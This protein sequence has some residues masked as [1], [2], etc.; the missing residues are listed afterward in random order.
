MPKFI[1]RWKRKGNWH[2]YGQTNKQIRA[3]ERQINAYRE[4][5]PDH[6]AYLSTEL[7]KLFARRGELYLKLTQEV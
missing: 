2:A 7:D 3:V 4:C 5:C 6:V 1:R